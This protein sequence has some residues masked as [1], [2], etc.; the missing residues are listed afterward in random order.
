MAV[1]G[2]GM[3]APCL[4]GQNPDQT[5]GGRKSARTGQETEGTLIDVWTLAGAF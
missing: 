1:S 2:M 3:T 5:F 4:N